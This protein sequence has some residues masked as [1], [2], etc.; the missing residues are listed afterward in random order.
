MKEKRRPT[1]EEQKAKKY[2]DFYYFWKKQYI[3]RLGRV[4]MRKEARIK[5]ELLKIT[6][7]LIPAPDDVWLHEHFPDLKKESVPCID[8]TSNQF[9]P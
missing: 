4:W 1:Q 9:Q 2:V 5:K 3:Q 7:G 6:S 8:V